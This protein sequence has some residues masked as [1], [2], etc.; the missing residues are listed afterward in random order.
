VAPTPAPV[1]PSGAAIYG[2]SKLLFLMW[3]YELQ[4]RL[5]RAGI[6]GVDVFAT[7][8]GE[9]MGGGG[10]NRVWMCVCVRGG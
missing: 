5:H 4:R 7:H 9:V 1:V 2:R 8:P 3:S 6:R 10:G